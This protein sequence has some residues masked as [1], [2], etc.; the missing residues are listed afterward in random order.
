[1][2]RFGHYGTHC[3]DSSV[4]NKE[5]YVALCDATSKTQKWVW[6][7]VNEERLR[8]YDNLDPKP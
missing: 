2:I 5:V 7:Y 8:N 1:M 6:S 4:S 3:L